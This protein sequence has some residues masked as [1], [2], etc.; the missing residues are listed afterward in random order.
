MVPEL[1]IFCGFYA[2]GQEFFAC[3]AKIKF[4]SSFK[5]SKVR[6]HMQKGII[7]IQVQK[8][9]IHYLLPKIQ[10]SLVQTNQRACLA[11]TG[12]GWF[13]QWRRRGRRGAPG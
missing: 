8:L 9:K 5:N 7:T 11:Q 13:R 1:K 10:T 4:P 3:S 12:D 2:E 6:V